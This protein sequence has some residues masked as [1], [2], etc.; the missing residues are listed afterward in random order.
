MTDNKKLLYLA[1]IQLPGVIAYEPI[2]L[3]VEL[4][5]RAASAL[6]FSDRFWLADLNEKE[7]VSA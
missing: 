4:G 6:I 1:A 2:D 5:D 7:V 3:L